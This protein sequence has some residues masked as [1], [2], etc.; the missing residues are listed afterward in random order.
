MRITGTASYISSFQ[1]TLHTSVRIIFLK[2]TSSLTKLLLK[3]TSFPYPSE[4][5]PNSFNIDLQTSE[6]ALASPFHL[7]FLLLWILFN[8]YNYLWV[9]YSF[10]PLCKLRN[11]GQGA[12]RSYVNCPRLHKFYWET[13]STSAWKE[14]WGRRQG[15]KW[16]WPH[17]IC[18][19]FVGQD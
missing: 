16:Q 17:C 1:C 6:P 7:L 11:G 13:A 14:G 15:K 19:F 2:C 8:P 9:K 5:S 12:R 3:L 18:E 4:Q 10:L